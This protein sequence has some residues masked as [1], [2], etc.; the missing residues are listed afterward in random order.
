MKVNEMVSSSNG[1][2][3]VDHDS[4]ATKETSDGGMEGA[5][6]FSAL[7][8]LENLERD[9]AV[10]HPGEARVLGL[11]AKLAD[12]STT[13]MRAQV[14]ARLESLLD[15]G[16]G[17][18][19]VVHAGASL[20]ARRAVVLQQSADF[21]ARFDEQYES[22]PERHFAVRVSFLQRQ[23][24][25]WELDRLVATGRLCCV[26]GPFTRA[27]LNRGGAGPFK[28]ESFDQVLEH[29]DTE[30]SVATIVEGERQHGRSR[31]GNGSKLKHFREAAARDY[32]HE[33]SLGHRSRG[34]GDLINK[35]PVERLRTVVET[36]A[37]LQRASPKLHPR[38][39]IGGNAR[40][41]YATAKDSEDR[42]RSGRKRTRADFVANKKKWGVVWDSLP[43]GHEDK[44]H[45]KDAF[46]RL[47]QYRRLTHGMTKSPKASQR[48]QPAM[49][50]HKDSCLQLG[51]AQH[52]LAAPIL[53]AYRERHGRGLRTLH[54]KCKAEGFISRILVDERRVRRALNLKAMERQAKVVCKLPCSR[55]YGLTV[56]AT[57][58]APHMRAVK[59]F[60]TLFCKWVRTRWHKDDLEG[61]L[62]VC[63]SLE[64]C[65]GLPRLAHFVTVSR[66]QSKPQKIHMSRWRADRDDGE[67]PCTLTLA[68]LAKCHRTT[69]ELG[70]EAVKEPSMIRAS[71]AE[72]VCEEVGLKQTRVVALKQGLD[73]ICTLLDVCK[74]PVRT[75]RCSSTKP[76]M[77]DLLS[78][79]EKGSEQGASAAA[80]TAP[81]AEH[82]QDV[83]NDD[84]GAPSETSDSGPSYVD[85]GDQ[86]ALS[87]IEDGEPVRAPAAQPPLAP[88]SE[89]SLAPA[90]SSSDPPAQPP[91]A[92]VSEPSLAPASSSSDPAFRAPTSRAEAKVLM[93]A[94]VR[95]IQAEPALAGA[96]PREQVNEALQRLDAQGL[97][98]WGTGRIYS[99]RRT[100]VDSFVGIDY[101]LLQ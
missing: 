81:V 84:S 5:N 41:L 58:D 15:P 73:E 98:F 7:E 3:N 72:C 40:N 95:Q 32:L 99:R 34:L 42:I 76:S 97:R 14:H 68:G 62:S 21:A 33:W 27:K 23:E 44:I 39:K 16:S 46:S 71:C 83:A 82:P 101:R 60:H 20:C 96:T 64:R 8:V 92:P 86:E 2:D 70:L 55:L 45:Y 4:C 10:E 31:A 75:R 54:E 12:R 35:E 61:K 37:A 78:E 9:E 93:A 28:C 1:N 51:S 88:V 69:Y 19:G 6:G 52:P 48:L 11:L 85:L 22:F 74:R 89:P 17:L 43:D 38:I 79:L 29:I 18:D 24:N 66:R 100:V 77:L 56:C 57:R 59:A 91:L 26:D 47:Q 49:G 30:D 87:G 36:S 65:Q 80:S 13:G 63:I 53:E 25:H 67:L 90:S 50:V 94:V